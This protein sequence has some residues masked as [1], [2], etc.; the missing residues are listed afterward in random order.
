MKFSCAGGPVGWLTARIEPLLDE[1]N[2]FE[3]RAFYLRIVT[4]DPDA[5]VR[6]AIE[7]VSD[8][9]EPL[10]TPY[11]SDIAH[12]ADPGELGA[13]IP[14]TEISDGFYLLR[15][16]VVGVTASGEGSDTAEVYIRAINGA[17]APMTSAE[18]LQETSAGLAIN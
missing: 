9:G 1:Q 16:T 3:A 12:L 13:R 2:G 7:R 15:A 8:R 6:Y 14:L 18:W 11:V 4:S 17:H 10:V 5:K